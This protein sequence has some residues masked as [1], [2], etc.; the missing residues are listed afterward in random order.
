M[1]LVGRDPARA[2]GALERALEST[3][4]R[5]DAG[6]ADVTTDLRRVDGADL[7]YE[8][9]HERLAAKRALYR[10]IENHVTS[11]VPL[12]SGTSSLAPLELSADMRAPDRLF[13]AHFVHPV[14]TVAL[15]EVLEPPRPNAVARATFEQWLLAMQLHPLVLDRP[16]AGF[17]VNRLQFAILREAISLV[18]NGVAEARDVDRVITHALGPRWV[19]TGPLASMDLAGL[20]LLRDVAR[21]IAPTLENGTMAAHIEQFIERGATGS[22]AGEGFRRWSDGDVDRAVEGRKRS[23]RFAAELHAGGPIPNDDPR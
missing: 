11:D 3:G 7:V 10:E 12:V 20:E 15:T 18:A 14:T 9:I 2:R 1:T 5:I 22:A 13:V 23:Y 16:I 8:A 19:A 17:L 6:T 21:V 4:D